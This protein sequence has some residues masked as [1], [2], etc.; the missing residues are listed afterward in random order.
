VVVE[1][2]RVRS[3]CE[4]VGAH[5]RLI[6]PCLRSMTTSLRNWLNGAG[7]FNAVSAASSSEGSIQVVGVDDEDD[8]GDSTERE[9]DDHAPAFPALNS[10]QR[11][12]SS[13]ASIPSIVSA[14]P[15]KQ[16]R[17]AGLMP[18]PP[19]PGL[20]ARTPGVGLSVPRG[21]PNTLMLPPST[22]KAAPLGTKKREKVA[23][24]P[25]FGPLDWAS[26]KSSGE[27]LR[28]RQLISH[29]TGSSD[30]G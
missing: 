8:D 12:S 5:R 20:A 16:E 29:E 30:A 28:V 25:G 13:A 21:A 9:D 6:T 14:A 19:N 15:A 2:N 10:A 1:E 23:L 27:D 18:P 24:A 17:A 26:L 11:A 7:I 4:S 22:T 3:R